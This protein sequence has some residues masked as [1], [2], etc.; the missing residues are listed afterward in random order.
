MD[1]VR[2]KDKPKE[3]ESTQEHEKYAAWDEESQSYKGIDVSELIRA[4]E[5]HKAIVEKVANSGPRQELEKEKLKQLSILKAMGVEDAGVNSYLPEQEQQDQEQE[6]PGYQEI[7]TP[8]FQ[9]FL[10]EMPTIFQ[11]Q[12]ISE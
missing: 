9:Q 11:K 6:D 5:E 3:T 1:E 2:Q 12:Q 10:P 4:H 8:D 7:E